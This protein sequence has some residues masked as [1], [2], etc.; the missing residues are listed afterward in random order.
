MLFFV[1]VSDYL[2]T[3][4][5]LPAYARMS[6]E[7]AAVNIAFRDLDAF[8][9]RWERLGEKS[10]ETARKEHLL[11]LVNVVRAYDVKVPG[12]S[13]DQIVRS[14]TVF[15]AFL[16][17][18]AAEKELREH[19]GDRTSQLVNKANEARVNVLKTIDALAK[20]FSKDPPKK[21]SIPLPSSH[22]ER[23]SGDA[24]P[25]QKRARSD[26]DAGPASKKPAA[27]GGAFVDLTQAV[28][29][30]VDLTNDSD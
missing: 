16:A 4:T 6:S 1:L 8:E 18:S 29:P 14:P 15:D 7:R 26:G 27:S 20:E 21:P 5:P 3:C 9:V 17:L 13:D 28:Q 23:S 24:G 11:L 10:T 30:D 19:K 2:M 12:F 25:A 22:P